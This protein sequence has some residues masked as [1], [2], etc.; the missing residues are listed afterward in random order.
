MKRPCQ[1]SPVIREKGFFDTRE[2]DYESSK[3]EAGSSK[4]EER[5]QMTENRY[6][7]IQPLTSDI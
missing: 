4:E 2:D 5:R 3:L 7:K 1:R 6:K